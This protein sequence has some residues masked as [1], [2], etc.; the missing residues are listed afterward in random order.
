MSRLPHSQRVEA[1]V[2]RHS[3]WGEADRML[4]LF[5]RELGK[6]RVVAK[7]VRRLRSR[8]AGHLEPFTRVALMLARG[9]DIW[10]VTQADTL[11]AFLPLRDNLE[12]TAYAAYV[13][14]LLDRF[15]Y[16]EGENSSLYRLYVE[17][18]ER[19]ATLEDPVPAIRYYEVR[20]LDLL[21]FRPELQHCVRCG[22]EIQPEAQ[23]FSALLGGVVCPRCGIDT[24]EARPVSL[25][26]LKFLRHYQRSSYA[27]ATRVRLPDAVR[28]ELE[29]LMQYY[30]T[31]LLERGLNSPAFLREVQRK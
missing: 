27:D 21:G 8:K 3:D 13:S 12:R 7:G 19:V 15:T 5:T 18:L 2:L 14:E 10:I 20:L 29:A 9:R 24:A 26:A 25:Q 28:P 30:L 6:L 11:D 31:Y 23:F 16:E 4:T 1:V 17:G 22:N